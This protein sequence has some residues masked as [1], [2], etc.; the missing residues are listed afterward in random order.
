MSVAQTHSGERASARRLRLRRWGQHGGL[1]IGGALL[2]CAI[3]MAL[4][5]PLLAPADPYLQELGARL[6]PPVWAEGG[7]WANPLGT[8]QL[9][10][11]YLS[12]LIYGSRISLLIGLGTVAIG[13]AIG[14]TLGLLAGFFGGRVDMVISFIVTARLAMPVML[15]ALA[16]VGLVGSSLTVVILVLGLLLWDQFAIV[17]RTAVRQIRDLDYIAAARAVGSSTP[18]IILREALPNVTGPILVVV[19]LEMAHAILLEAALS[20]LGLGVQPPLPSWGLMI[21]EGR[22][23]IFFTPWVIAIPGAALFLLV[24]GINL[25]GDGVRDVTAPGGR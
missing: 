2:A 19:T 15:V 23:Y 8:D 21:A 11:D 24:L 14:I 22:D 20:F 3:V 7:S 17:T 4:C 18:S 13:G 12:R 6:K 5:A 9:G 1:L 25:F 16:V 10:R